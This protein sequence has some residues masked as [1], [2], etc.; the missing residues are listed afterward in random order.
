MAEFQTTQLHS[1]QP[2]GLVEEFKSY[3]DILQFKE[4]NTNNNHQ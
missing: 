3:S 4:D 2:V 1:L